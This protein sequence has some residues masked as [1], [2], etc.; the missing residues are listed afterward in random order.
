MAK[1]R[2]SDKKSIEEYDHKDK[3]RVNNPPVGIVTPET[4]KESGKKP[5]PTTR[6]STHNFSG[7]ARQSIP[8]LKFPR[9]P[10]I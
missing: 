2:K 3:D 10:S 6:T 1:K 7:Q 9:F 8:L 4:D 5:M